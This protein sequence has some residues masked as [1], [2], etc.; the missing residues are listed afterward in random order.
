MKAFNYLVVVSYPGYPEWPSPKRFDERVERLL[1]KES[2]GGGAGFGRRDFDFT[3]PTW[4]KAKK[5]AA[6]V[7]TYAKKE[8]EAVY[9]NTI[10]KVYKNELI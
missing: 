1:R 7:R 8:K 2:S 10:V 6:K 4:E 5:A 3:Y 9:R